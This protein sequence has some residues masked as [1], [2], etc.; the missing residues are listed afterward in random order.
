MV[1]H[2]KADNEFQRTLYEVVNVEV[3]ASPA[4]QP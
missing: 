3:Q 1:H 4:G 2:D